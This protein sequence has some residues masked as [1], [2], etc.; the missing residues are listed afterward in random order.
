M[1]FCLRNPP[2][3]PN[4]GKAMKLVIMNPLDKH[5]RVFFLSWTSFLFSFL[6]WYAMPPLLNATIRYDLELTTAQIQ[7]SNIIALVAGLLMRLVAGTLCEKFGPR[8]VLIGI[9]WCA[10]LPTGLA[11]VATHFA[12]LC[13]IR[14]F[15]GIGG[16][17]FVPANVLIVQYFDNHVIGTAAAFAAGW[18]DAGVGVAFFVMPSVFDSLVSQHHLRAPV[19]WRVSF[20]VP[21]IVLIFF[22]I[23]LLL[24]VDDT[25]T[26]H[27][28]NRGQRNLTGSSVATAFGNLTPSSQSS[29]VAV[30]KSNPKESSG[31]NTYSETTNSVRRP[32]A[33]DSMMTA[34]EVQPASRAE[35]VAPPAREERTLKQNLGHLCCWQTLMLSALYFST[36]GGGL[37]MSSFLVNWYG[38]RFGWSQSLAG[39]WSAMFGL[40]N[41][42]TRPAGG[43]M[44]DTLANRSV[45]GR[46]LHTKKYW[47]CALCVIEG[48]FCLW[49]GLSNPM[50]STTLLGGMTGIAIFL[51]AANGA[52]YS[53]VPRVNPE[54]A[55]L[56][57]GA[58]GG[59]GNLGGIIFCLVARFVP[60][61]Q[62]VWIVGVVCVVVGT[63]SATVPPLPRRQRDVVSQTVL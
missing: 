35:S 23:C 57:G 2:I 26:G 3:N 11:G 33:A 54:I 6:A 53:L 42:V 55:G 44:A 21:C 52:I 9:L 61:H 17:A 37:A 50:S 1:L 13:A 7:I 51:Q 10:A 15:I 40:L 59:S 16:A 25:P 47:A 48:A 8:Y 63:L 39:S 62:T 31:K 24:F 60:H 46:E 32:S 12:S 36:F 49:V 29:T 22:G 27:W 4:N 43:L 45:E 41:F 14:F 38:E 5:G 58:V 30:D 20:V 56:M 34:V 19:A 18:G 28:R